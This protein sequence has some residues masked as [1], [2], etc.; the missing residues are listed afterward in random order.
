M[1]LHWA[2]GGGAFQVGFDDGGVLDARSRAAS[3][4]ESLVGFTLTAL[5]LDLPVR[6]VLIACGVLW[7]VW[8]GP[9]RTVVALALVFAGLAVASTYLSGVPLVRIVY[10]A[11]F[12]W[13]LPFRLLMFASI[14]LVLLAGYGYIRV[15]WAWAA[16]VGRVRGVAARRRLQR[17][18][19]L[20]VLTWLVLITQGM[21]VFLSIPRA[22][23]DSFTAD[24]SA[25]MAWLR[26]HA[27]PG[28]V[29]A[30]DTFADAGI[31]APYK[32]G[33]P[34]LFYRSTSNPATAAARE[35]VL[36]N[37]SRLDQ[38]PAAAAAACALNVRYVYYGAANSGWQPRTFPPVDELR[39]SPA[40]E[41]AFAQ[42]HAL[43][44][45]IRQRCT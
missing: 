5:G 4:A 13:S 16:L 20:A 18:G 40:L 23:L 27:E 17:V 44:L 21:I 30:N 7:S 25:A 43:V 11:T 28:S 2:G 32:A 31:W 35:F 38:S 22:R 45:R 33:L 14:P 29:L 1:L 6:I 15:G 9:G 3:A 10:A 26:Q 24:D 12:P 39:T 42:G 36:A 34:I 37:I 41:V 8:R 19:R